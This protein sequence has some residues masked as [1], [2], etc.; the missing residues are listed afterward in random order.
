MNFFLLGLLIIYGVE[1]ICET[2]WKRPTI[3]GR[4]IAP[5]TLYLL[6]AAHGT[7]FLVVLYE[8]IAK[9]TVSSFTSSAMGIFTVTIAGMV[10]CYSIRTL[11][12][13][14]SIQIEIREN[15][16]VITRGPYRFI[17]N[18]YYLSNAIEVAGFPLIVDSLTGTALCV[19]LYWPC[20]YLRIILEERA[21]MEA[22]QA[23][24]ANYMY[25]VP[26]LVPAF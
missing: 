5:Y 14:H 11:G 6:V 23:P 15:H 3:K 22:I 20:L 12:L 24:F 4:V 18:P 9:D 17:R 19:L 1:R 16:P 10:R 2:F 21:L 26:R 7:I 8:G 25:R 13:Y